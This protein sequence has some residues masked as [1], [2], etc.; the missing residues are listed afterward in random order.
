M[1]LNILQNSQENRVSFLIKLE[2]FIR[3]DTH[4]TPMKIVQFST[5]PVPAPLSSYVQNSSTPLTLD[6]QFQTKSPHSPYDNQSIK[7]KQSKDDYYVIL[8]YLLV[9]FRFQYQLINLA[10]LSVDLFSLN[11][12]RPQS[13]LKKLKTSLLHSSYSEKMR[14]GQD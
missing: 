7:R 10:W 3:D 12:S 9:G 14:C 4:M 2:T 5:P 1:F 6:V 13:N 11:Q 8:S